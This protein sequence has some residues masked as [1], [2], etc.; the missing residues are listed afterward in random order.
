MKSEI[1]F[2]AIVK[3]HKLQFLYGF[4]VVTLEP[5][6]LS[7]TRDGKKV[8]FGRVNNLNEIR[9]FEYDKI[10]NIKVLKNTRFTPI[11]PIYYSMN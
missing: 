3:R 2:E 7:S 1:F 8:V 5:Y 9:M 11:I 4:D 6:Y 10:V